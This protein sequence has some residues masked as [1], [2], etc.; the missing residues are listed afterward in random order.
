MCVY[1]YVY[2]IK[3]RFCDKYMYILLLACELLLNKKMILYYIK[4]KNRLFYFL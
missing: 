3:G 2:E 1:R 4:K